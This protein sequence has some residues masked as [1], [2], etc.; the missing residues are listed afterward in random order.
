LEV[1]R[2][3]LPWK[4]SAKKNEKI[5]NDWTTKQALNQI[6]SGIRTHG[7]TNFELFSIELNLVSEYWHHWALSKILDFQKIFSFF[8]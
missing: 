5:K 6:F 3:L 4:V 8:Y 7:S 1:F 2:Y